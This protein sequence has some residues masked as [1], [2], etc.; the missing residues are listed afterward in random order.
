M[1]IKNAEEIYER[2]TWAN[3]EFTV[4]ALEDTIPHFNGSN[5]YTINVS[6]N[7]YSFAKR[8][9]RGWMQN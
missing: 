8:L 2:T 6:M 7:N 1:T 4:T 5:V 3:T 9:V